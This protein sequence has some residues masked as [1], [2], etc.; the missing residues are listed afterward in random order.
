MGRNAKRDSTLR[1]VPCDPMMTSPHEPCVDLHSSSQLNS[2][3]ES[4]SHP[5]LTPHMIHYHQLMLKC[6]NIDQ[7]TLSHRFSLSFHLSDH[8]PPMH[9]IVCRAPQARGTRIENLLSL[10][11]SKSHSHPHTLRDPSHDSYNHNSQPHLPQQSPQAPAFRPAGSQE[12]TPHG[13]LK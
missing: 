5:L 9:I 4:P 3:C 7:T 10:F 1:C 8:Q 11:F 6:R 12:I 2:P 13:T